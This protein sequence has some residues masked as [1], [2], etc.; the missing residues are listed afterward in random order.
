[1]QNTG[2]SSAI[3]DYLERTNLFLI[4]MDDERKWYRFHH[5]FTD[6][7]RTRLHQNRTADELIVLHTRATQ[8][9]EQNGFVYD[10][11]YHAS[12][13]TNHEWVE[14]LIDQNYMEIFQRKDSVSIRYWTGELHEEIIYIS[15]RL[16]IHEANS[17]AWFGQLDDADFLLD[18]AEKSIQEEN[19][20]TEIQALIGYLAYVRSRI[21]AMRGDFDKAI[22]LCIAARENTPTSNQALLGG[23]GVMLGYGY[24]LNGDFTHAIQ[25]LEYTIQSGKKSGAVNT[26]IGAYCV[27]ARLYAIQGRLHKAFK[28]YQEAENFI[29]D[30]NE[31]H[32][33]AMSIV[34]VGF[35]ELHY[36]WNDIEK[37]LDHIHLGLEYLPLWGKADDT[38]LA[39]ILYAQVQQVQGNLSTAEKSIE[40]GS[41]VIQTSGVFSESRDAVLTGEIRLRLKQENG[42]MVGHLVSSLENRLQSKNP[43]R[44]ENELPFITLARVYLSQN[45]IEGAEKLLADLE[46]SA[47]SAGRI[48]RLIQIMVLQALAFQQS[49][50]TT[51]ALSKLTNCLTL[52]E[53]EGFVR[54][55]VDEGQPMQT[56]LTQWLSHTNNNYLQE[57]AKHILSQF[58][59][60]P[61]MAPTAQKIVALGGVLI[62]P[63]S[64]RET[65]VLSLIALGK[66]NKEIADQ[67]I[68]SPGTVKAHTSSIYRKLDVTNRTE[69]VAHAR[70]LGLFS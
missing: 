47:Q 56:L 5:L 12:L 31:Q 20:S 70:E 46:K 41:Q 65:E 39:N 50:K 42:L 6:L 52:A 60:E 35:A 18:K 51:Q 10:A 8:W 9:Y 40:K 36:E 2:Q 17:R 66:T 19:T 16:C 69:A 54:I 13:T 59:I 24:F 58:Q 63:L 22:E 57:Y 15:P 44:F 33:G 38:A 14:K 1:M 49:I 7:L 43:F 29:Q 37:A 64:A 67:L 23:I 48:G 4:A 62:E 11:I 25:T 55:F 30:T 34:D 27:L 32:H 21:T 61:G 3:I 28:L 68:I 26:T 45:K 53:P